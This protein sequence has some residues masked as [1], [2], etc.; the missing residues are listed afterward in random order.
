[1]VRLFRAKR[2]P[3]PGWNP[4]ADHAP[5]SSCHTRALFPT[6]AVLSTIRQISTS[7]E[8][9]QILISGLGS[10]HPL[11]SSDIAATALETPSFAMKTVLSA[12]R[13]V[14]VRWAMAIFVRLKC[15]IA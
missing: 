13:M 12:S 7:A 11:S 2:V 1:M 15:R 10:V 6:A 5:K 8:T 9:G 4:L 3:D 14:S